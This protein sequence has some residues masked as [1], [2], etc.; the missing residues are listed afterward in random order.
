MALFG[1]FSTLFNAK[2][3]FLVPEGEIFSPISS[4]CPLSPTPD[5]RMPQ[6]VLPCLTTKTTF[7]PK[8]ERRQRED[9]LQLVECGVVAGV[10]MNKK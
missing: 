10:D 1:P 6:F 4:L 9:G 8:I 5:A 2:T 3:P 7:G